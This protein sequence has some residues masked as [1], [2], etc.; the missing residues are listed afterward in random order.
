MV[1]E[2][3][4]EGATSIGAVMGRLAPRIKWRFDGREANRIVREEQG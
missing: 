2:A 3:I 1:R 4:A